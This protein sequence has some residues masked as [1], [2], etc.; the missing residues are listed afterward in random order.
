MCGSLG[1]WPPAAE[2]GRFSGRRGQWQ[3]GWLGE[4]AEGVTMGQKRAGKLTDGAEDLVVAVARPR[5][6]ES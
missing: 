2:M 5:C 1:P 3:R 6:R 4:L